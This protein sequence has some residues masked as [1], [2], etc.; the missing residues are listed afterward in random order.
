MTIGSIHGEDAILKAKE[1]L[2]ADSGMSKSTAN[3]MQVILV[4]VGLLLERIGTNSSN[5]GLPPSLIRITPFSA[6]RFL[7]LSS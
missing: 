7:L 4:L 2:D 6:I 3:A 1:M 5:S